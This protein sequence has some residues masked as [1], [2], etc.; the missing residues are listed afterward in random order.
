MWVDDFPI[1]PNGKVDKENLPSPEYVRPDS[2]PLLKKPK[3]KLE[4]ELADIWSKQ[5][6]ISEIGIEDNFFEMGGTSLLSQKVASL[7][8]RRLKK[9]VPVSKIYQYPTIVE[10]SR[11]IEQQTK[12][13]KPEFSKN[14]KG[15][16]SSRGIQ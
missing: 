13:T 5:L 2:A 7:M 1:T 9:K 3:T 14:Q 8:K 11:Y 15:K 4:R 10:L 12:K 16:K 6:L